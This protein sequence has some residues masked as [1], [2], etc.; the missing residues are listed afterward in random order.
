MTLSI[1]LSIVVLSVSYAKSHLCCVTYKPI[2]LSAIMLNVV[3]LSVA[4]PNKY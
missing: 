3:M 4:D 1:M 2:I